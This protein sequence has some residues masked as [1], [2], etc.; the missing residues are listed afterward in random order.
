MR[1]EPEIVVRA[2]DGHQ[3]QADAGDHQ[4]VGRQRHQPGPV[5]AHAA[6]ARR[7]R[8]QGCLSGPLCTAHSNLGD[9]DS[10]IAA[11]NRIVELEPADAFAYMSLSIF[12]QRK[13]Q[14]P[15][16]EA[17]AAKA[18]MISCCTR[19]MSFRPR[20]WSARTCCCSRNP[21]CYRRESSPP[22]CT[23]RRRVGRRSFPQ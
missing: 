1:E 11:V 18:R 6:V 3:T 22:R 2:R 19:L 10:A 16:A 5:R 20:S 13:G 15:E 9:Q 21:I 23:R 4:Q 17:A 14:I 7:H 12:L 8:P